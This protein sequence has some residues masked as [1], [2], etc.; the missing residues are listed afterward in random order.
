MGD[1]PSSWRGFLD[2]CSGLTL[3][4]FVDVLQQ[5]WNQQ[6]QSRKEFQEEWRRRNGKDFHRWRPKVGESIEVLCVGTHCGIDATGKKWRLPEARDIIS[7]FE[8]VKGAWF[9]VTRVMGGET[10]KNTPYMTGNPPANKISRPKRP[11]RRTGR[12]SPGRPTRLHFTVEHIVG[13]VLQWTLPA[14]EGHRDV[15]IYRFIVKL[16]S[17]RFSEDEVLARALDLARRCNPPFDE[18]EVRRKVKR[19]FYPEPMTCEV[20]ARIEGQ[21]VAQR[22]A[23]EPIE[24][25]LRN[26]DS[27]EDCLRGAESLEEGLR[28]LSD[29]M[30]SAFGGRQDRYAY[31]VRR[32]EGG[33][34]FPRPTKS[35]ALTPLVLRDHLAG[36]AKGLYLVGLDGTVSVLVFDIDAHVRSKEQALDEVRII[37]QALLLRGA[38]YERNFL[39]EDSGNGFHIWVFIEPMVSISVG[40]WATRLLSSL[41]LR[42]DPQYRS[43]LPPPTGGLG[44][45]GLGPL[46]RLPLGLHPK[47]GA[48]SQ[49]LAVEEVIPKERI[50][51]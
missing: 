14:T 39:V 23:S 29:W 28:R 2:V 12:K 45:K 19:V 11:H 34:P 10:K 42:P 51:R 50:I 5:N 38:E 32:N 8:G 46:I 36:A 30:A 47:N 9:R 16:R 21:R 48:R 49:F 4:E 40:L 25:R 24:V 31:Y 17:E 26:A 13:P 18:N 44:A 33:E 37:C 41:G 22:E 1:S 15:T 7:A 20:R 6:V 27:L 43:V 3:D 35:A